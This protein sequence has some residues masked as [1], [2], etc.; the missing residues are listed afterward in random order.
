MQPPES[1]E[2]QAAVPASDR[3]ADCP[4]AVPAAATEAD[5]PEDTLTAKVSLNLVPTALQEFFQEHP[6]VALAYSG[7]CDSVFL[8]ACALACGAGVHPFTVNTAFQYA[9]E[10][11]DAKAAAAQLGALAPLQILQLDIFARPEVVANPPDRCYHCKKV[12]FGAILEAAAEQGIDLLIDG[13][14][15]SDDPARRPGFRALE[16][17]GVRSPLREAGLTKDEIRALSRKM[18]LI[19]AEKPNY[20]CLATRVEA[21]TPI[22]PEL[23]GGF[24]QEDWRAR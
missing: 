22:T 24:A 7:G 5:W 15:A 1:R 21:H 14:N 10:V 2:P 23:L 19:T 18:G 3:E 4:E 13:T 8:L 12:I 16:E 20:S 9:F 17:F 11:E 6:R